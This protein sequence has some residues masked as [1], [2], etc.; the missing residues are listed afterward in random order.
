MK[1]GVVMEILDR[2]VLSDIDR[3]A[4]IVAVDQLRVAFIELLLHATAGSLARV[5]LQRLRASGATAFETAHRL[6]WLETDGH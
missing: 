3:K 4:A 5:D 2:P 1:G 6:L